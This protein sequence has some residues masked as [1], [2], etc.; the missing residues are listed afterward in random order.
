M[1]EGYDSVKQ[2]TFYRPLGGKIEF[3]ELGSETVRREIDEE[4]GL[5]CEVNRYLGAFENIFVFN[6]QKGH[7]IV[8]VYDGKFSDPSVYSREVL[9]GQEDNEEE[10]KA[11]WKLLRD[12]NHVNIMDKN[13]PLENPLY[14]TGL[15]ELLQ[16]TR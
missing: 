15:Q 10:F 16:K 6:G 11:F 5:A 13:T 14:P 12:F 7:E 3:G 9:L 4:L 8:L 1:A 2:Q